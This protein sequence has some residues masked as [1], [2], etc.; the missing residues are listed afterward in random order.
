MGKKRRSGLHKRRGRLSTALAKLGLVALIVI[1]LVLAL[2]IFFKV[3]SV[4]VE[5]NSQ[6]EAQEILDVAAIKNGDNMFFINTT[7]YQII[8]KIN[9][10]I[11][12]VNI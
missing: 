8:I 9:N 1:L 12:E 10:K 3:D 2:T 6:Y 11:K 5:G 4:R 7:L